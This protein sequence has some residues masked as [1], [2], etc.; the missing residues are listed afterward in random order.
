MAK[1]AEKKLSIL[2]LSY[3]SR[4][5]LITVY[6]RLHPLLEIQN[7]QHEFIIMDDG[8]QDDTFEIAKKLEKTKS[9]V[10]AHQLSRNHTSHY[11]IFAALSVCSGDCAVVIPDDEQQPYDTIVEM[12][13][14]WETGKKII[15]PH[16]IDRD[17]PFVSKIFSNLFYSLM[18]K[19]S[20]IT[21]P[22]GGADTFFIDR[23]IIDILNEKIHPI[24][25]TTITEILRLGFDPVY[26]PYHRA[27]SV[28]EKSRWSFK[29]KVKLAADTFFSCSS[30]PIKFIFYA[31]IFFSISSFGVI[32]F[33]GYIRLF[34]NNKF[35]GIN[36]EGWTSL[37]FFISFFSGL[38]LFGLGVIAEYI[39]RIYE[40]VKNRP[41]YIIKK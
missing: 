14:A 30:F 2:L 38:I 18:N 31:G 29:K 26:I 28:N 12:Y 27:K 1:M 6:D 21:Y 34:G 15:I 22:K 7:I 35:W 24:N 23:E 39:W 11:S 32:L 9:N 13:R 25:T 3:Y 20:D 4:E 37:V 36:V 33:Y 40:E 41:G 19:L 16:R 17:D 8:S 10:L 5:K